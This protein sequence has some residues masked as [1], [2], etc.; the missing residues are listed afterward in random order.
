MLREKYVT[1][2]EKT[3]QKFS[4]TNSV[5]INIFYFIFIKCRT[6]KNH[7]HIES[8]YLIGY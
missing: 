7:M 1:I 6:A 2:D 8:L 4:W 5:I 3:S